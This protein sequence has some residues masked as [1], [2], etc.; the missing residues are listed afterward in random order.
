MKNLCVYKVLTA[1]SIVLSAALAVGSNSGVALAD[2]VSDRAEATTVAQ[3]IADAEN[4]FML[5]EETGDPYAENEADRVDTGYKALMDAV[6]QYMPDDG[7][8]GVSLLWLRQPGADMLEWHGYSDVVSKSDLGRRLMWTCVDK[9]TGHIVAIVTG[10]LDKNTNKLTTTRLRKTEFAQPLLDS[11]AQSSS[12][13]SMVE[14]LSSNI[15]SSG[16]R[17]D[18]TE[19][20]AQ[21]LADAR[22]ALRN[23]AAKNGVTS[24]E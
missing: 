21:S 23:Q 18:L 10:S 1:C 2:T 15:E 3:S 13:S 9:S 5:T 19:K 20:E 4:V 22:A 12:V 24:D 17:R 16:S 14:K 11:I 6:G 8:V 7:A